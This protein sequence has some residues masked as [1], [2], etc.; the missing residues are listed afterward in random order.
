MRNY[1]ASAAFIFIPPS[2]K[3]EFI[4]E[5]PH[6]HYLDHAATTPVDP[7]AVRVM[8]DVMTENFG[9]PSAQYQLGRKAKALVDGGR[10]VIAKALDAQPEQV[11]FTSCGTEGDNWAIR[12]GLHQNRRVGRHIVTTAVEHRPGGPLARPTARAG[13]TAT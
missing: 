2:D 11:L 1:P 13:C 7:E 9:N 12:A 6:M 3:R 5:T 10:A 8:V 4:K